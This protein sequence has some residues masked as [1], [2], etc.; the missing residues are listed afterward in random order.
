M[1]GDAMKTTQFALLHRKRSRENRNRHYSNRRDTE[2]KMKQ[3]AH[4]K[5]VLLFLLGGVLLLLSACGVRNTENAPPPLS[6]STPSSATLAEASVEEDAVPTIF[7]ANTAAGKGDTSVELTVNVKNNPGIL[8][9]LFSVHYD[10]NAMTLVDCK[11]G[12]AVAGLTLTKPSSYDSGCN[13]LWYGN[14]V[15]EISDGTVLTLVFD[16]A[17]DARAGTYPLEISYVNG[18]ICDAAYN[19]ITFV[20]EQG[21]IK[22]S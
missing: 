16:I 10:E 6:D 1:R 19:P 11:N 18:D 21:Y 4:M 2:L 9:M 8:G 5:T 17:E 13:F 12:E 3:N 15:G 14:E 20:A 7:A 22:V